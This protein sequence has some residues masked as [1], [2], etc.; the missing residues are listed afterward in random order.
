MSE[1]KI[2]VFFFDV[3]GVL[4]E[5]GDYDGEFNSR[6]VQIT[7]FSPEKVKT[8]YREGIQAQWHEWERGEILPYQFYRHYLN[9]FCQQLSL[10]FSECQQVGQLLTYPLFREIFG[11]VSTPRLRTINFM[12]HLR[13]MGHKVIIVS[14][15]NP[16]HYDYAMR[17][18]VHTLNRVEACIF[19]HEFGFRKPELAIWRMALEMACLISGSFCR[20][21]ETFMIDDRAEHIEAARNL[22]GIPGHVFTTVTNLKKDLQ[23]NYGFSFD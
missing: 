21:E 2:K 5:S 11:G 14:N 7:H 12:N 4:L 13:A 23:E 15:N 17:I 18:L 9:I 3:G 20:P 1:P 16:I 8:V 10:S 6:I 19:S 22:A